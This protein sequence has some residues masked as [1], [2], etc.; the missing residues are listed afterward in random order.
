MISERVNLDVL[1]K[2]GFRIETAAAMAPIPER[3]PQPNHS[4]GSRAVAIWLRWR[5]LGCPHGKLKAMAADA[6]I[7]PQAVQTYRIRAGL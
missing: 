3:K 7:S 6:G 5:E 2:A 1:R 4:I